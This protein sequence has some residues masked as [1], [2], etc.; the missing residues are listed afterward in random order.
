MRQP[1]HLVH[2]RLHNR[3]VRMADG[4]AKVLAEEINVPDSDG[5]TA[6]EGVVSC[7][8]TSK[9]FLRQSDRSRQVLLPAKVSASSTACQCQ[10]WR[11]SLAALDVPHVLHASLCR[12][13]RIVV[14]LKGGKG[15]REI[16]P[17]LGNNIVVDCAVLVGTASQFLCSL[18][19]V[20]AKCD[21]RNGGWGPSQREEQEFGML[22]AIH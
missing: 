21:E 17:P 3:W 11:L 12:K 2:G 14:G 20:G 6:C 10:D 19:P 4:D 13:K 15:G 16:P 9:Q 22:F 1:S 18:C 5:T 7:L 8:C